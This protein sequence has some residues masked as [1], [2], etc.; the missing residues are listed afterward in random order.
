ML[1]PTKSTVHQSPLLATPLQWEF[2]WK[3][4]GED[5]GESAALSHSHMATGRHNVYQM[6]NAQSSTGKRGGG[7]GEAGQHTHTHI[8]KSSNLHFVHFLPMENMKNAGCARISLAREGVGVGAGTG[9]GNGLESKS[10]LLQFP[11]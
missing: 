4:D 1:S 9:T 8:Q 6:C 2:N 10:E 5:D 3:R 11:N 7:K